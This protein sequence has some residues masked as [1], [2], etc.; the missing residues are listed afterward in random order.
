MGV[1]VVA[2]LLLLITAARERPWPVRTG[3]ELVTVTALLGGVCCVA[4]LGE[5]Q[6]MFLV[7][8]VVGWIAWRFE[9]RG[10]A[11]AAMFVS[12]AATL[13]AVWEIGP[14]AEG[15][16]V[17]RM[18]VLQSFNAT[19]AF[20]SILL[21]S[22]VSQRENFVEHEH[23]I[24]ESLQ[25][26]LLSA[27]SSEYPDVSSAARY[28]PAR[29]E[30]AVGGD[31]Y[32][33]I[34]LHDGRLGFV[35]GDV[36]GH[37]V[38]AAAEMGQLRMMLRAY[39]LD[40][41]S[42]A[43]TLQRVNRLL[44][45]LHTSAMATAWYGCYDP[46]SRMLTFSSAGHFPALVVDGDGRGEYLEEIHGPPLGATAATQYSES[47]WVLD[48]DA[49]LLLYTDGL[50][51]RRG[52]PIDTGLDALRE[53]VSTAPR[54]LE[55]MCDHIVATLLDGPIEDDVA[56]L[57]LRPISLA[58]PTLRLREPALPST[59]PAARRV[60]GAWLARNGCSSDETF[61]ILV[62]LSEAYSN[63]VQHAYRVS[64]GIVEVD[65]AIGRGVVEITVADHGTWRPRPAVRVDGAG[66]GIRMMRSLMDDVAIESNGPGTSVRMRRACKVSSTGD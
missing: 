17:E 4:F 7:L 56:L 2:P 50:V 20:S 40:D 52:E 24:A 14:F 59:L 9:Q 29:A 22:A 48:A 11:P 38:G 30:T 60:M 25:R 3:L 18:V 34:P 63:A 1:L 43:E 47:Q 21:A 57:A 61:D 42:P 62:A 26:S 33:V 64:P 53:A 45:D 41:H 10:A 28:I 66:K 23:N 39:A 65:A 8:P 12:V 13:A 54:N 44:C 49:T 37:G 46:A 36:A 27:T 32:D 35:V 15:S 16:L 51:E 55:A 58:G 6:T 5:Q 19:V 31:W